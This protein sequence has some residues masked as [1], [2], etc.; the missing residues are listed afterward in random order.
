MLKTSD[1]LAFLRSERNGAE[2]AR[3]LGDPR[4]LG[5]GNVVRHVMVDDL[6]SSHRLSGEQLIRLC[7]AVLAGELEPDHLELVAFSLSCS[8]HFSCDREDP[9]GLAAILDDWATPGEEDRWTRAAVEDMRRRLLEAS[10]LA[11][12]AR[13]PQPAA[14]ANA[15]P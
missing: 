4:V 12:A 8:E 6:R 3:D 5:D 7:D 14:P 15:P 10:R 9:H 2:L 13:P 1:V 11:G